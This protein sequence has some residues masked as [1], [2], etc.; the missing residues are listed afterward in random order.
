[1]KMEHALAAPFDGEVN[2]IAAE[3]GGQVTEGSV[4]VKLTAD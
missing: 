1:M 4:L 3:L 2:E